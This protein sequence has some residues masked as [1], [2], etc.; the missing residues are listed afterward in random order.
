[1][2]MVADRL[3]IFRLDEGRPDRLHAIVLLPRGPYFLAHVHHAPDADSITRFLAMLGYRLFFRT[4]KTR[5][6]GERG[7]A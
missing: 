3:V 5:S 7:I 2:A 1:M 6:A 4:D